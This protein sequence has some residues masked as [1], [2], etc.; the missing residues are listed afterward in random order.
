MKELALGLK[1]VEEKIDRP[2][3]PP[4]VS[5]LMKTSVF[6][7]IVA[8]DIFP[9]GVAFVIGKRKALTCYHNLFAEDQEVKMDLQIRLQDSSWQK[10]FK[11]QFIKGDKALDYAVLRLFEDFEPFEIADEVDQDNCILLGFNIGLVNVDAEAQQAYGVTTL[12]GAISKV[13]SK[14]INYTAETFRGDSGSAVVISRTGQVV[15]MHK[16]QLNT[17]PPKTKI[18]IAAK[19]EKR[20]KKEKLADDEKDKLADHES[21]VSSL[22]GSVS[23][24]AV[25][26]RLDVLKKKLLEE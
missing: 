6:G 7:V 2:L 10:E 12:H 20:V 3:I 17:V 15:A 24:I 19:K 16:D 21:L 25:A 1:K 14:T 22:S 4:A 13:D 5:T 8:N 26:L 23:K 18:S 11:A 9:T